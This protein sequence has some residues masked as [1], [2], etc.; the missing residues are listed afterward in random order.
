[1]LINSRQR[2]ISCSWSQCVTG[3][4]LSGRISNG[5]VFQSMSSSSAIG[6]SG[7]H[8]SM[9]VNSSIGVRSANVLTWGRQRHSYGT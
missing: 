2:L 4:T 1:M 6:S 7:W 3:F 5:S 9:R 8:L